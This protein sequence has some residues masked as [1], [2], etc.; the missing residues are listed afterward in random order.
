MVH[1]VASRQ[2]LGGFVR[3]DSEGVLIEVE[4]DD[5]TSI[6][7]FVRTLR[8]EAPQLARID[9][10]EVRIVPARNERSF[11]FIAS[12]PLASVAATVPADAATCDACIRELFDPCD[13]RFRYPFINCT[14]CG[15]RYTIIRDV[16]YDRARTTMDAFPMCNACR[17]E[18]EDPQDRRFHAEPTACH[19]CGPRVVLFEGDRCV[20]E[21]DAAIVRAISLLCSGAIVAVKGLGGYQLAVLATDERAVARLRERKHR[22]H[23]PFALMANDLAQ[24]EALWRVSPAAHD[25]L[26]APSHPIVLLEAAGGGAWLK[27]I[28]PGLGEIGVML[29]TAP[30]HHLLLAGGGLLVMTSA[31]VADEPIAKDDAE[32]RD[33]LGRIADAILAHNR[34]IHTRADDSVVRVIG[35]RAR[36][37][38]RAR[39]FALDPVSIGFAAP[40]VLGVGGEL[41]NAVCL[42]RGKDAFLSQHIGDLG[43]IESQAFFEEVVAKMTQLVGVVPQAIAHDLHP[44]YASTRWAVKRGVRTIA[45]QHH[46][47]HVAACLAEHG[48]TARAIGVAFDG[49]GCGPAGE[50]WG[51]EILLFDLSGFVRLGHLRPIAL[52]GGE[53][54]IR[55]PWRLAVA[56]LLDAGEPLDVLA[57]D[58]TDA[59]ARLIEREISSPRATGAGRWFDAFA[60]ILG[61]RHQISYEA[62]AAIELEALAARAKAESEIR[63]FAYSIELRNGAPFVVDLRPVVRQVAASLRRGEPREE[64]AAR[65]Y[66]TMAEATLASCRLARDQHHVDLVALSGGCFQSK[67]LTEHV[68]RLLDADGFEVLVHERVPPNDGGLALGQAA[69]AAYRL[70]SR[71]G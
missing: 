36:A 59:I 23:K 35:G 49:T 48:R 17:A 18:Y 22:P 9:A 24:I 62:Q 45:V 25:A 65:V 61:V 71:G 11:R 63:A 20:A 12:T 34:V 67:L 5:E 56:A 6:A 40:S 68:T 37:V 66:A 39:G 21:R 69:V 43:S 31:N 57:H 46:H 29:P 1:R 47:A 58:R 64:A 32:A 15:P 52:A 19:V 8:R 44:D 55:E 33:K 26:V 30:L 28:A 2:A 70:T 3:N 27:N 50:L 42:T 14:D 38:R 13:R 41:K 53:A 54:A 60:S 4:A 10:L 51:G 7:T 16:P